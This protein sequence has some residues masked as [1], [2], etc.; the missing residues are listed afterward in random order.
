MNSGTR[1]HRTECGK[2][3]D[4]QY[5]ITKYIAEALSATVILLVL[6]YASSS[7]KLFKF[8]K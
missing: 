6:L 1:V 5:F 2:S 7:N 4:K 3:A 8:G